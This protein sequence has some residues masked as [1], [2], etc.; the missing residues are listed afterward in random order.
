MNLIGAVRNQN[1]ICILMLLLPCVV[2]NLQ[3]NIGLCLMK[4]PCKIYQKFWNEKKPGIIF[5]FLNKLLFTENEEY[6]RNVDVSFVFLLN[7][8]VRW[9]PTK[10]TRKERRNKTNAGSKTRSPSNR[11]QGQSKSPINFND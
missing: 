10:I 11:S 6:H 1:C 4:C 5:S 7:R 3:K 9:T 8:T 2:S